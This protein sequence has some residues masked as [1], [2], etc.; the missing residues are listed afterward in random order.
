MMSVLLS[1]SAN[2]YAIK[3]ILTHLTI[4]FVY[5]NVGNCQQS[6]DTKRYLL[7]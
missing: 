3:G 6:V 2:A 1:L 4:Y 7:K 5:N